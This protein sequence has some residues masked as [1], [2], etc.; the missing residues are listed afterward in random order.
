MPQAT[1]PD[2]DLFARL[3]AVCLDDWTA[4]TQHRFVNELAAGSLPVESFR[5]FLVQDYQ[6]L[7][8][9]ARAW[10]LAVFKSDSLADMREAAATLNALLNQEMALH[11]GYCEGWGISRQDL[12]A[13][14]EATA[15]MAYTRYVLERGVAGDLLDL[16]VALAP[17]VLGYGEIGMALAHQ[18]KPDH[19][20]GQWISTYA[21]DEYQSVAGGM[22]AQLQRTAERLLTPS[23]ERECVKNFGCATRLEIRFW[24]MALTRSD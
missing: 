16:L 15:N 17:C 7:I 4:Y 5:H 22:R 19:P 1:A 9:F 23:R 8:H 20:Y 2:D 3:R 11:V 12:E 13:Q 6:F 18:A 10:A 14:P 24:D 21:G